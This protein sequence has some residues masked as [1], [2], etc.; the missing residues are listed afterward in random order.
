MTIRESRR[1]AFCDYLRT[2][3]AG[4]PTEMEDRFISDTNFQLL[5]C[6]MPPQPA[7]QQQYQ[8]QY[9]QH[10]YTYPGLQDACHQPEASSTSADASVPSTSS[11]LRSASEVLNNSSDAD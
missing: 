3:M 7:Y 8:Q 9:Q 10:Q 2:S 6:L 5:Q 1:Q 4:M 11:I